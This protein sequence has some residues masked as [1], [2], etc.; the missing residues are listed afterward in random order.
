MYGGT[1][2]VS[3]PI[4]SCESTRSIPACTGEPLIFKSFQSSSVYPRVYGGTYPHGSRPALPTGVYP[5]VYGGT[6]CTSKTFKVYPR[7]YGG[8]AW[9]DIA[10]PQPRSIPACTGEPSLSARA[11]AE[12]NLVYP[13]VYGGTSD[14][15]PDFQAILVSVYPRVYGG[16]VGRGDGSIAGYRSIPACT[17]EPFAVSARGRCAIWGLSPRV[18]GNPRTAVVKQNWEVAVYPRVYGGTACSPLV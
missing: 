1:G 15:V 14:E 2:N 5:R 16:T 7:V 18:R 4:V 9:P 13:R 17:G 6:S 8:T 10:H 3:V 11:T 12:G